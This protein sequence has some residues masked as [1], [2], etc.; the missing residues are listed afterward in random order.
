MKKKLK[1]KISYTL[2]E[3]LISITVLG[4]LFAVTILGISKVMTDNSMARFKKGYS[5]LESSVGYLINNEII[6][7]TSSG[8]KNTSAV[9]LEDV[10]QTLGE[11]EANKFRDA[12]KYHLNIIKDNL[13]CQVYYSSGWYTKSFCF[14]ADDGVVYGI[15]ATNF[16]RSGVKSYKIEYSEQDSE[17]LYLAP[18]T[19]HVNYNANNPLETKDAAIAGVN[20]DGR[21]FLLKL[22]DDI[23]NADSPP[24]NCTKLDN[25]VKSNT[26]SLA[27]EENNE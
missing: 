2:V 14:M 19:M 17:T 15:P 18:V 16:Q 12:V 1:I 26:I 10:G 20:Y 4:F 9:T 8:F 24:L 3:I 23:C 11:T 6:Y 25:Y 5:N 7:G 27:N 22:A 13:K 21:V